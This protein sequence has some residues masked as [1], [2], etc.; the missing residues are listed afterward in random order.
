MN[1]FVICRARKSDMT[2]FG[3]Y[4][5]QMDIPVL[6]WIFDIERLLCLMSANTQCGKWECDIATMFRLQFDEWRRTYFVS[7][8]IFLLFVRIKF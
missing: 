2:E 8:I 5:S 6:L 7:F 1:E 4:Y 3:E